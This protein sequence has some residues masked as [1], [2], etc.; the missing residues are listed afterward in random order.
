LI[1][2]KCHWESDIW[3]RVALN[4][5][6]KSVLPQLKIEPRSYTKLGIQKRK[7]IV[8]RLPQRSTFAFSPLVVP[9]CII[10]VIRPTSF[11][12]VSHRQASFHVIA[13][14]W[15]PQQP[16]VRPT[17]PL[18]HP[19]QPPFHIVSKSSFSPK[20][21]HCPFVSRATVAPVLASHR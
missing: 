9:S 15:V 12:I 2:K 1:F 14:I 16:L 13:V 18:V 7:C 5:C 19:T 21:L 3:S 20:L 4:R 17:K 10:V 11:R 6:Q 8:L